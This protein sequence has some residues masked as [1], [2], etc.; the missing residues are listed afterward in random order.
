[1]KKGFDLGKPFSKTIHVCFGRFLIPF[2]SNHH[3]GLVNESLIIISQFLLEMLE[4]IAG[5]TLIGTCHIQKK[6]KYLTAFDVPQ[7]AVTKPTVFSSSLN[8]TRHVGHGDRTKVLRIINHADRGDKRGERIGCD[9]WT[10]V[11]KYIQKSGLSGIGKTH[12]SDAGDGLERKYVVRLQTGFPFRK[13]SG[14]LVDAGLEGC[15]S[16]TALPPSRSK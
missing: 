4:V 2:V 7:E 6:K 10:C 1:M 15:V 3:I 11:G 9:L 12:K 13:L 16:P 5:V 14:S 8:Q